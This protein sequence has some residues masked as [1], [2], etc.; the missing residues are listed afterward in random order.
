MSQVEIAFSCLFKTAICLHIN[1]LSHSRSNKHTSNEVMTRLRIFLNDFVVKS[2]K[3]EL[4]L[5]K[6]GKGLAGKRFYLFRLDYVW[7][8][9][10]RTPG[11]INGR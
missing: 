2:K 6:N 5:T 8:F 3:S 4:Y 11:N 9:R 10:F 1:N 7:K